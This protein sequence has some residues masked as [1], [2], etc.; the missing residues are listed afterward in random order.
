MDEAVPRRLPIHGNVI[1]TAAVRPESLAELKSAALS[2]LQTEFT[3]GHGKISSSSLSM[4][5]LYFSQLPQFLVSLTV[6]HSLPQF[7]LSPS[8]PCLS[9]NSQSLPYSLSP[10]IL[11][12]ILKFLSFPQFPI[13][14]HNSDTSHNPPFLPPFHSLSQLNSLPQFNFPH[15]SLFLPQLLAFT[16]FPVSPIL[17]TSSTIL[18]ILLQFLSPSQFPILGDQNWP[19]QKCVSLP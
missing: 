2:E 19:P 14:F 13:L 5:L 15:N 1:G 6:L 8:I 16:Q 9:H 4:L 7:P 11:H 12:I 17:S 18:H 3:I 10:T